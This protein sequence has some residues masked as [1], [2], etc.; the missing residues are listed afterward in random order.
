MGQGV[1][2]GDDLADLM[3]RTVLMSGVEMTFA[4]YMQQQVLTVKQREEYVRLRSWGWE[5]S[6][7]MTM[8]VDPYDS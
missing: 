1:E 3:E 2:G 5:H 8:A 6:D 7:A 4:E